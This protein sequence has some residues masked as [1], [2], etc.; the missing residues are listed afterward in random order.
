MGLKWNG[1]EN[2]TGSGRCL[3]LA[4]FFLMGAA[5]GAVC[6]GRVSGTLAQELSDY[7][8]DYLTLSRERSLDFSTVWALAKAYY[9]SSA[10]AFFCGFTSIGLVLVPL[11]AAGAGFFPTYAAGCLRAVFGTRGL[12]LALG[13][14]GL[15]CLV[16]L[17]C[18]F[19][20]AAPA[21]S[22]STALFRVSFGKGHPFLPAYG[23]RWWLR[24]LGVC[25]ILGLGLWLDL[26]LTPVFLRFL[27]V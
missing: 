10:L 20:L 19:L 4:A 23:G 13:L 16:T 27:F 5:A 2:G 12:W 21:W 24:F 7:L 17:P 8:R 25:V 26:R 11:L 3:L 15:R 1:T 22:A 9:L 6:A 14:F 18:F